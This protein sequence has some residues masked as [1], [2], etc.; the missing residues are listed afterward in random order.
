MTG[1]Q[2]SPFVAVYAP[3][4]LGFGTKFVDTERDAGRF[5]D[6]FYKANQSH[7]FKDRHWI[8]REFPEM[9]QAPAK[10]LCI[11][12]AGCGVGNTIYPLL[13][14]LPNSIVYAFDFSPC[15]VQLVKEHAGYDPQRVVAFVHDLTAATIPPTVPTGGI[16]Y[17]TLI[18]VLSAVPDTKH[19]VA[20]TSMAQKLVSGGILYFRDYA[21]DDMAQ[22]RFRAGAAVA[23]N[24]FRRQD[25][26]RTFF[27]SK[28]YW[29]HLS[30]ACGFLVLANDYVKKTVTNV[31]E[32]KEMH[33]T[34]LQSKLQKR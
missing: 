13:A 9:F 24:T 2:G 10:R 31:K 11:M 16:H 23:D 20:L 19:A 4:T 33:R 29:A 30:E 18:F 5:W 25:G 1:A 22:K 8:P 28:E 32:Q 14:D 17:A 7:F 3:Y 21:V 6:F 12:E 27:F 26:T 34:F 15:A